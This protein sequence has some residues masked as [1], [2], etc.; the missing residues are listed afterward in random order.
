MRLK[1]LCTL[2]IMACALML[3]ACSTVVSKQM[4]TGNAEGKPKKI[5]VFFDGTH[6]DVASDTNVKRL[7]SLVT[8]QA[9]DDLATIYVEGVGVD[10]DVLGMGLGLGTG[11]RVKLAY[12]FLLDHYRPKDQIY[13]FG[14][15]RGAYA[16][17]ILASLL[18]YAGLPE[19]AAIYGNEGKLTHAELAHE[20]YGAVK[21]MPE[22]GEQPADRFAKVHAKLAR[23]DRVTPVSVEMLGLW[24]TVEA[25]GWPRW[26][27]HIGHL[28]HL[29]PFVVDIDEPNARYGD[30]LCNV[31]RAYQALSIDDDREWIFT[32]LLLSRAHVFKPCVD[33][34]DVQM[35][36]DA[37]G[38]RQARTLQE[39]WFA[40]AHS[41]VGGGYEDSLLSGVS[42]NWMID[43]LSD[44]NVGLLPRGMAVPQD[45]YGNSHDPESKWASFA[46][47]AMTRN[48]GAYVHDA[49]Q[50]KDKRDVIAVHASVF[51]RRKVSPPK[52]HENDLLSL[53]Q[54]GEV[55]LVP[56]EREGVSR[57]QRLRELANGNCSGP[58]AVRVVVECAGA[59]EGSDVKQKR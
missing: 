5:V 47:H 53:T 59:C 38:V 35:P 3:S 21:Y 19:N 26:G 33:P 58:D 52:A 14:F 15:S 45:P 57:P 55:C 39:V 28:L 29:A 41:D 17:R 49:N 9:R 30:Q 34:L 1:S 32:P 51:D 27:K 2:A 10:N 7:H 43:K 12:Q 18:Y 24:D 40:G 46:Y 22:P 11:A 37:A 54:A 4:L 56:D 48:I 31:V 13:I 16:A 42:L 36:K 8:L 44:P 6:N 23:F 20:V 25:L 50:L